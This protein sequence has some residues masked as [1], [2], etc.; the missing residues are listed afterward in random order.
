MPRNATYTA[1]A[2]MCFL[3]SSSE[4][5][6]S[7]HHH[8]S[9]TL[10]LPVTSC[11]CELVVCAVWTRVWGVVCDC[12]VVWSVWYGVVCDCDVLWSVW[13]GVVWLRCCLKCEGVW[14]VGGVHVTVMFSGV[15]G[16][17]GVWLCLGGGEKGRTSL[18]KTRTGRTKIRQKLKLGTQTHTPFCQ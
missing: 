8:S 9:Y 16:C 15:W 17:G 2:C 13:Y 6:K 5:T 12:D 7:L 14:W 11:C 10:S 1:R 3:S 18:G 4:G